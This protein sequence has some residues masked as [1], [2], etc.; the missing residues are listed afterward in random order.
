MY[1]VLGKVLGGKSPTYIK[2]LGNTVNGKSSLSGIDK[3]SGEIIVKGAHCL[4]TSV[5]SRAI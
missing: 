1:A 4:L 5:L 3:K 2:N